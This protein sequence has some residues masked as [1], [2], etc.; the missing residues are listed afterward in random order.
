[1]CAEP[2]EF[3]PSATSSRPII[4][5]PAA[6]APVRNDR[7]LMLNT[8]SQTVTQPADQNPSGLALMIGK[9]VKNSVETSKYGTNRTDPSMESVK[10][11]G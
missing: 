4:E 10:C 1:M 6:T 8:I 11:K 2:V 5:V 9:Q 7:R 3:R